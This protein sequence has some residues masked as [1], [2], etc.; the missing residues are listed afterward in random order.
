MVILAVICEVLQLGPPSQVAD[1]V[2]GDR[3]RMWM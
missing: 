3:Y 1:T 2:G